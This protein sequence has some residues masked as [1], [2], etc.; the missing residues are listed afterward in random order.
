MCIFKKFQ[1]LQYYWW[2]W[3]WK[4]S[5][6]NVNQTQPGQNRLSTLGN[7]LPGDWD[8][9]PKNTARTDYKASW[10]NTKGNN[11]CILARHS[12]KNWKSRWCK[13]I[14]FTLF[15]IHITEFFLLI[16]IQNTR[17]VSCI[18]ISWENNFP[19]LLSP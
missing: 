15:Q 8:V 3:Q 1:Q 11:L 10:F 9:S 4:I 2:K 17:K 13:I 16:F 7:L 14:I 5:Y 18:I 19:L 6:A 12:I